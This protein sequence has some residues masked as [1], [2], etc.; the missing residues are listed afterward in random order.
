MPNVGIISV[1]CMSPISMY[2]PG[3]ESRFLHKPTV[4][5]KHRTAFELGRLKIGNAAHSGVSEVRFFTKSYKW[6]KQRWKNWTTGRLLCETM[7]FWRSPTVRQF[8]RA[9]RRIRSQQKL[10]L[11]DV[12]WE[13]SDYSLL[14][15]CSI[16]FAES[17]VTCLRNKA[18]VYY[19]YLLTVNTVN[20]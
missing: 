6:K 16:S 5:R 13:C 3:F 8:K 18:H 4:P 1:V 14:F 15:P 19:V 12:A 20:K 7:C 9:D 10:K 2:Q 11:L 17:F